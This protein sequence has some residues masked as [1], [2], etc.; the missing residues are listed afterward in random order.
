MC[1]S[2]S[3]RFYRQHDGQHYCPAIQKVLKKTYPDLSVSV[4]AM[5]VLNDFVCEVGNKL[6]EE[7]NLMQHKSGRKT[8]TA[9]DFAFA[10][11]LLLP[12]ELCVYSKAK[13]F[14]SLSKLT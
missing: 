7:A 6:T 2:R 14:S 9:H 1:N 8:L 13:V 4:R 10:S 12:G 3:A 11:D 5:N